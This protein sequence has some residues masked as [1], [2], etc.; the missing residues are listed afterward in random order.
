MSPDPH[1]VAARIAEIAEA[2]IMSR[3]GG[4]SPEEVREKTGPTDLVTVVDEAAERAL[5][6]AL[7]EFRPDAAFVGEEMAARDPAIGQTITRADAVWIV[8]PLDGTRNFIR[9]VREFGVIVA[10][11]EKGRARMGWIYAAPDRHCAIAVAGEGASCDRAPI[12]T[13]PASGR[14]RALRSLGWLPQPRQNRM[15]DRLAEVFDSA[16]GHCS[17]YAYLKLARGEIDLKVSSRIHPWDHVAG[18]LII[19]EL[20]GRT[21]FLDTGADY[22]PQPSVDAPL[23]AVAP[24]RDWAGIGGRLRD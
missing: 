14:L 17:A 4:I 10:L 16:P 13:R 23:L 12:R 1:K 5:R 15:R 21:A 18:A 3:F 11:V 2:E 20:G 7:H 24:G 19:A 8:D 9:G 22:A 6:V